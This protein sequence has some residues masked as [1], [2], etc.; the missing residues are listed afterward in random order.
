[1]FDSAVTYVG[2]VMEQQ[3]S[4]AKGFCSHVVS[5]AS[6]SGQ[7]GCGRGGRSAGRGGGCEHNR[8]GRGG[9]GGGRHSNLTDQY[10][11]PDEW[12]KLSYEE[13]Q[14]VRD[15]HTER[16][17]RRNVQVVDRNVHSRQTDQAQSETSSTP[18]SALAPAASNASSGVTSGR[19]GPLIAFCDS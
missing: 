10:Y 14:T 18:A 11:K 4:L 15:K 9:R 7:G 12:E 19:T 2:A 3:M 13:C 5:S 8:G 6:T 1:L 16:D 17:K